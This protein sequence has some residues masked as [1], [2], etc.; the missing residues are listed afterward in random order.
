MK[1]SPFLKKQ[2]TPNQKSGRIE[3][4]DRSTARPANR[5]ESNLF[6]LSAD[7]AEVLQAI[8]QLLLTPAFLDDT[9]Q[10]I[11]NLLVELV[12]YRQADIIL[13]DQDNEEIQ[14]ISA[15][16]SYE[17]ALA[18][19]NR[20]PISFTN[21]PQSLEWQNIHVINNFKRA[22]QLSP[23]QR[24]LQ[25]DG[26]QTLLAIPLATKD[27]LF[28][29]L[30]LGS[31]EAQAY[32][33]EQL[34][35]LKE[36]AYFITLRLHHHQ[37]RYQLEQQAEM[38]ENTLLLHNDELQKLVDELERSNRFKN[39]FIS[40]ASHELRTPLNAILGKATVLTEGVYGPLNEKQHRAASV[41][42]ESGTHLLQLINNLLDWTDIEADRVVLELKPVQIQ[43]LFSQV[44]APVYATAAEKE[45]QLKIN[46]P[47]SPLWIAVDANQFEKVFYILFD[48]AL[49]FTPKG[50]EIGLDIAED[51][52]GR[53]QI[54]IWDTGIG[55]DSEKMGL[56]FLPFTQA[57]GRLS[58]QYE[59]VG[60]GLPLAYRLVHLHNGELT[61]TSKPNKGT[62]I[63]ITLPM[64][65]SEKD[66]MV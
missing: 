62:R 58:R 39:E 6:G 54:I 28:G 33:V 14:I 8:K 7:Q 13:Y 61:V 9:L 40:S 31:L 52:D 53:L 42:H 65:S 27:N 59:G 23:M 37:T 45:L 57:D 46:L 41:I 64:V 38:L 5:R 34:P 3:H 16:T 17:Y 55:I 10:N 56:L 60:L 51:G 15:V 29:Y 63:N 47:A 50:G 2:M 22:A 12:H 11:L 18:F 20:L 30:S 43:A 25:A 35:L 1:E 32:D 4:A 36:V 49:K 26:I 44:L 24:S 19:N 66:T 21:Y 48:N